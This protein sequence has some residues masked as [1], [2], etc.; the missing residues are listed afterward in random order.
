MKK[1]ISFVLV[2]CFAFLLFGC[3]LKTNQTPQKGTVN[4]SDNSAETVYIK[5]TDKLPQKYNE[6]SVSDEYETDFNSDGAEDKVV[7][8]TDADTSDE[9]YKKND[10]NNWL[11]AVFDGADGKFYELFTDYVQ[12][13]N[14]YFQVSD[15]FK[16]EKPYPVI[17][18]YESTTSKLSV[19]NFYYSEG[20]G[21]V[22]EEIYDSSNK[23]DKGINLKYS[24]L[25]VN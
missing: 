2:L 16:D 24:S 4:T 22:K 21:F 9:E 17:T 25:Q 7:L 3:E 15:Y 12:I 13:G 20:K 8:Y 14:V 19:M 23:S 11:L 1:V 18:F 5:A 6:F 10:G